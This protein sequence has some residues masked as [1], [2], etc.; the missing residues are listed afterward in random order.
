MFPIIRN[1]SQFMLT[2]AR[3]NLSDNSTAKLQISQKWRYEW[4]FDLVG[5]YTAIVAPALS[6]ESD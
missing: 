2:R 1:F 3:A 5:K 6:S 4:S